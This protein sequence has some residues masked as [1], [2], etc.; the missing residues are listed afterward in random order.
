ME[1]GNGRIWDMWLYLVSVL[2]GANAANYQRLSDSI[3]LGSWGSW[4]VL[5]KK[6]PDLN[7]SGGR[8]AVAY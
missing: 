7:T 4:V 2:N 3:S 5:R 8:G 6:D 1:S